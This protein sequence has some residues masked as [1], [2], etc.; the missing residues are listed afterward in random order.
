MFKF[1][2]SNNNIGLLDTSMSQLF[3]LNIKNVYSTL[4]TKL[5]IFLSPFFVVLALSILF[6][7]QLF[8]A[9]GQLFVVPLSSGIVFGMVY[10][11]IKRSTLDNNISMTTLT[12]LQTYG[13]ILLTMLFVTF[14][15]ELIF[16]ITLIIFESIGLA[17]T[18]SIINVITADKDL[19]INWANVEWLTVIYYWAMSTILM[20]L[21]SFLF[22]GFTKT[23]N[24][25]YS[26]LFIYVLFL[27][28][29]GGLFQGAFLKVEDNDI[30]LSNKVN[31]NYV[32][33]SFFPQFHLD[34]FVTKAMNS[35]VYNVFDG[36]S[37]N[38]LNTINSFSW[39]KDWQWNFS[40][41]Y[42]WASLFILSSLCLLTI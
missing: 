22:R 14:I 27:V 8:V 31:F 41:L 33:S 28:S 37:Y 2:K 9:A 30:Y 39:S 29:F 40:L 1:I 16:W 18:T 5:V 25:Y 6:P 12:K 19:D 3:I 15:S 38:G 36:T 21:G 42:P 26:V 7:I 24:W 20:F 17:G 11:P 10:F 32:V 4:A 34:T 23:I 13:T 35:G